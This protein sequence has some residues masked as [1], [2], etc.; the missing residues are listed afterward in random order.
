MDSAALLAGFCRRFSGWFSGE[1]QLMLWETLFL[2]DIALLA[3]GDSEPG[4]KSQPCPAH[5]LKQHQEIAIES[6]ECMPSVELGVT[7]SC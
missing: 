4:V 2:C 6:R 5:F 1:L 7:V 3:T